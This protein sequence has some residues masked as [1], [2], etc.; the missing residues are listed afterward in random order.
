MKDPRMNQLIYELTGID[1]NKAI[2]TRVCPFCGKPAV[3]FRDE[4]SAKEADISGLCQ[5]CQDEVFGSEEVLSEEIE[6]NEDENIW[7]E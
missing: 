7:G 6:N 5:Q 1:T 2:E 3:E 4:V